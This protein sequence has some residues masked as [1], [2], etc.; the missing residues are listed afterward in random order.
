MKITCPHCGKVQRVAPH[1]MGKRYMCVWCMKMLDVKADKPVSLN[2]PPQLA[3]APKPVVEE[4]PLLAS[5]VEEPSVASVVA[6]PSQKKSIWLSLPVLL[7]IP[8]SLGFL[9]LCAGFF[10]IGKSEKSRSTDALLRPGSQQWLI[11]NSEAHWAPSENATVAGKI[12]YGATVTVV[13]DDGSGW[14]EVDKWAPVYKSR[15]WNPYNEEF[16]GQTESVFIR[17]EH[18]TPRNPHIYGR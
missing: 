14:V 7:G 1:Y 9:F 6:E 17:K 16:L 8:V 3:Q 5:I 12:N 15:T 4:E 10:I 13:K 18:L 2:L 11:V